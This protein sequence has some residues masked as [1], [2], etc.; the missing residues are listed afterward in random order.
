MKSLL[1]AFLFTTVL[2]CLHGYATAQ[3]YTAKIEISITKSS[4]KIT[5]TVKYEATKAAVAALVKKTLGRP[6][7]VSPLEISE[8]IPPFHPDWQNDLE[9]KLSDFGKQKFGILTFE[10]KAVAEN[11]YYPLL[12]DAIANSEIKLVD[13]R[14]IKIGDVPQKNIVIA[15]GASWA[16]PFREIIPDLIQFHKDHPDLRILLID[17]DT[18]GYEHKRFPAFVKDNGIRFDSGWADETFIRQFLDLSGNQGIPQ[19]F[20]IS[21]GKIRGIFLGAS[22]SANNKMKQLVRELET[23]EK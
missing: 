16:G 9:Q 12:P 1:F 3:S 4:G 19:V 17:V 20:V 6:V 7:D 13:S 15:L 18:D 22:E 10:A 21:D 11:G 5:G 23:G 8:W 2:A 14:T